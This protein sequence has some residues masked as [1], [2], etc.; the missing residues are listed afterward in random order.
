[1]R[2]DEDEIDTTKDG[3]KYFNSLKKHPRILDFTLSKKFA[4]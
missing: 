2:D 4:K 3:V 1:M